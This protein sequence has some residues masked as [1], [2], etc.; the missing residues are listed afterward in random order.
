MAQEIPQNEER[1]VT[2]KVPEANLFELLAEINT[3]RNV[4]SV[5]YKPTGTSDGF[6]VTAHYAIMDLALQQA[7]VSSKIQT[8]AENA[9][10]GKPLRALAS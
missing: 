5:E 8:L 1:T 9:Q 6:E 3:M 10:K 4:I 2:V 7:V